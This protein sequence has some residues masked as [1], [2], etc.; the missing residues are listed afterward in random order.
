[1][2]DYIPQELKQL[3]QW[4]TWG[5]R[6]N[7]NKK[8]PWNPRTGY[9]AKA[10]DPSTWSDYETALEAVRRGEYEGLGFEFDNGIVGI[11]ILL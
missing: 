5:K 8:M 7:D 6:G 10:D 1:M 3:R 4:V 11:D 2:Y 9:G